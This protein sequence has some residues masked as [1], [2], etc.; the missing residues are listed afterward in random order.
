MGLG[1]NHYKDQAPFSSSRSSSIDDQ[2]GI[3]VVHY[4]VTQVAIVNAETPRVVVLLDQQHMIA[5][6]AHLSSF[7]IFSNWPTA[8]HVLLNEY[9][10]RALARTNR[11]SPRRSR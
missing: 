2:N 8:H 1:G 4:L 7:F 10:A 3:F 11:P 9:G 6:G 5:L